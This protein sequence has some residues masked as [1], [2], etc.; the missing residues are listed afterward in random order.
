MKIKEV[1]E[2]TGISAH[3]IRYYEKQGV[4]ELPKKDSSGHRNYSDTD[5]DLINWVACMKNS[6]M[7]LRDIKGYVTASMEGR[8]EDALVALRIHLEKLKEQK[9]NIDHYID[10]T[11]AK[12]KRLSN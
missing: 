8:N 4:L 9:K 6:G 1:S 5:V 12:I 3:T 11:E 7:S 10:V 2:F